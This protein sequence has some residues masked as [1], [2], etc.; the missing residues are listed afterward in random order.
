MINKWTKVAKKVSLSK[1]QTLKDFIKEMGE[2]KGDF[3]E[4]EWD[5]IIATY[6]RDIPSDYR[7]LCSENN[8]EEFH[9]GREFFNI[10]SSDLG[11]QTKEG[12]F[13]AL[14][15]GETKIYNK[16]GYKA[17][18]EGEMTWGLWVSPEFIEKELPKMSKE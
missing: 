12:D 14:S 16:D 5:K 6:R 13:P 18:L 1:Y 9:F 8:G 2:I 15:I 11:E 17:I 7:M 4:K 10:S 3:E